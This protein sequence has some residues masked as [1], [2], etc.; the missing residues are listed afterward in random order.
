MAAR[1]DRV[2]VVG[3]VVGDLVLHVPDLP[4]HGR[5]VVADRYEVRP[6]G[7]YRVLRA[8]A[9]LGLPGALGGRLGMG[10]VAAQVKDRVIA[11]GVQL[12]LPDADGDLGFTVVLVDTGGQHTVVTSP[13][14]ASAL[15]LADLRALPLTAGDAIHVSGRDLLDPTTGPAFATWVAGGGLGDAVL[16]FEPG[17]LVADIPDTVTDAV[18]SRSQVLTLDSHALALMGGAAH[19]ADE[20]SAARALLAHMPPGGHI[21]VRRGGRGCLVVLDGGP[22]TSFPAPRGGWPAIGA[23]ALHTGAYV[24]ELARC[25]D[26][27]LAA[28]RATVATGL[29]AG[30]PSPDGP[31]LAELEDALR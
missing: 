19:H 22:A 18:L 29:A 23:G 10:V 26:P 16:V 5:D 15:T 24:A 28:R 21:V 25:G 17:P 3:S 13:G 2:V 27:V 7:A 4:E 8:A 11:D 12:L 31:T 20:E 9:R 6:G 30:A 14:A 1:I